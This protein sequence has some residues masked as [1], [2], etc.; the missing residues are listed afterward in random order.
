M[1]F[2]HNYIFLSAYAA[3]VNKGQPPRDSI[4]KFRRDEV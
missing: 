1:L 3:S 2:M 4:K